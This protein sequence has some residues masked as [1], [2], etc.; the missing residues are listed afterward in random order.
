MSRPLAMVALLYLGVVKTWKFVA[1]NDQDLRHKKSNKFSFVLG[2]ALGLGAILL[3]SAVDFNMH[4]PANA[5]LAVA[6]M[7]ILSSHLRFASDRYWMSPGHWGRA[8]AAVVLLAG[9]VRWSARCSSW[10]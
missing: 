1:G 3:H 4:V 10:A 2:A 7:A 6:L 5:I 8:L 9:P